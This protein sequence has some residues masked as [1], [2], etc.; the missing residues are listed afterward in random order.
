MEAGVLNKQIRFSGGR[1]CIFNGLGEFFYVN[2][3]LG[4]QCSGFYG[5]STAGHL[6]AEDASDVVCDDPEFIF[7]QGASFSVSSSEEECWFL[8]EE[9]KGFHRNPGTFKGL[10][11]SVYVYYQFREHNPYH[12]GSRTG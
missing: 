5:K 9:A 1:I 4:G 7:K 11:V 2:D 3:V 10:S 8:S 6:R 12:R